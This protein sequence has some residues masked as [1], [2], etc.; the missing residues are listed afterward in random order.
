MTACGSAAQVAAPE[1]LIPAGANL[2][3]QIQVSQ[4]PQDPDFAT[5]YDQAPKS[6]GDPQS[7]QELLD[8]AQEETGIDF[9]QFNSAILFGDISRD[10]E[11]FGVIAQGQ[12]DQEQFISAIQEQ[13]EHTF[14][15]I[16]Y[17]GRQIHLSQDEEDAPALSFLDDTMLVIGTLPAVQAVIDVQEGDQ[18]RVS[19]KVYDTFMGLGDPLFSMALSVPPEA[20]TELEDSLGEAEG[21]GMMPAMTAFRDLDIVSLVVDKPGSELK[22]EAQ[23]DFFTTES[24]TKMGNT[25]DGFLKLAAGFASNEQTGKMM[26]KLQLDVNGTRL[27][28]KFQAPISELKEVSRSMEED[29]GGQN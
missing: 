1:N 7:F 6:S 16:D 3:A 28:L 29:F 5:L 9:R 22:M 2:I 13:S 25:L 11:Y 19:G 14:T 17:K 12:V 10:D 4:L 8:M 21:F 26:E 18:P 23:L 15:S 20:L 27:T 24:A